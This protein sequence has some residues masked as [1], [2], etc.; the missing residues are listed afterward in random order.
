MGD[1]GGSIRSYSRYTN[2]EKDEGEVLSKEIRR[3]DRSYELGLTEIW[4][5]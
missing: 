3:L 4:L 1:I 2:W 5:Q